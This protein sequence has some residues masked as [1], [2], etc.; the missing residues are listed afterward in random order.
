MAEYEAV[1]ADQLPIYPNDEQL[2]FFIRE[3]IDVAITVL[4]QSGVFYN[5]FQDGPRND[6]DRIIWQYGDENKSKVDNWVEEPILIV[7]VT[8]ALLLFV[9]LFFLIW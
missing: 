7:G 6:F 4:H 2:E 5:M 8:I 9:I 3:S 1:I